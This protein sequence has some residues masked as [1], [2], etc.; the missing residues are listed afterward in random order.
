MTAETPYDLPSIH[1]PR[2]TGPALRLF[3]WLLEIPVTRALLRRLLMR[4]SGISDWRRLTVAAIPSHEPRLDGETVADG[5]E[6]AT[7][8]STLTATPLENRTGFASVLDYHHAYRTG[9]TTPEQVARRALAA[10]A[11]SD[12]REPPLR[13]F[14]ACDAADVQQ[15]AQASSRRWQ[16]GKPLSPFDG[17]PVAVKDEFDQAPYP[18][19]LGTRFING[20]LTDREATVVARLRAA[21]ALLLGK[22]NL[23]EFDLGV[24]GLNPFH[25]TVRN[26]YRPDHYSGGSSGGSAAAVAAGLCPVAIGADAGGSIRTPAALCGVVG[27]KP[28]H[29]RVS[30]FGAFG[31]Q[32][33][34]YQVGLLAATARDAA[35]TYALIAGPDPQDPA[36]LAQPPLTLASFDELDLQGVTLGI[37]RPWFEHADPAVVASCD[38]LLNHFQAQGA[39][40]KAITIPDLNAGRI[41]H[42]VIILTE[43]A[44]SVA[45]YQATRRREFSLEVRCTLALAHALTAQD[46]G[47]A[48]RVRARLRAHMQRALQEVDA[49]VTP[50]TAGTAPPIHS[51]ALRQGELNLGLVT[52][53]MRFGPPANLTGLP[54]ITFPAGYD[55]QGLPI[56]CQ[57]IGRPW[58]EEVLLR[59]AQVAETGVV[60]SKP[61]VYYPLL[62]DA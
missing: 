42:L 46:Y 49:I 38:A 28:T 59:L 17:V 33:S 27:L 23:P 2:L 15:Q 13:A 53:L 12:V 35:L 37:Y 39:Q 62:P 21:G 36:S 50:T 43:F 54:A 11:D 7:V 51:D 44:Q 61:P 10:I 56:G 14:I 25:G 34:V 4:E 29:G 30:G 58:Q 26:P 41:A 8:L 3:T 5:T 6:N 19:T 24:T 31:Q 32:C 20:R 52:A 57:V 9:A 40:V 48:Q 55:A 60:R 22:T 16:E 45:H 1:S 18:T 47:H